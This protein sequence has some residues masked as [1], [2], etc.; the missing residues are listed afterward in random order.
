M[1]DVTFSAQLPS[2]ETIY[3]SPVHEQTYA[4]HVASDNLGGPHGYFLS[5]ERKGSFEVLAKVASLD[6]ARSLFSL[7]SKA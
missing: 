1:E 4:E 3:I 5:C 2:G 7:L 6:A